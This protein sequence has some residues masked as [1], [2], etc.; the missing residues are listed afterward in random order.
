VNRV[1][2]IAVVHEYLSQQNNE[3]IDVAKVAKGIY[4]AIMS[5][6]VV[7]DLKL[8]TSFKADAVNMPSDQAT[9]VALV[10]NELLQN[11]LEHGFEGRHKVFSMFPLRKTKKTMCF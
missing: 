7:P 9:S 3:A 2:S 6:M 11:S 10:L 1:N 8:T 5:S 4:E